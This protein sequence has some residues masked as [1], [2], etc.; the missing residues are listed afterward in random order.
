M[1]TGG[2]GL[3]LAEPSRELGEG[4]A[5]PNPLWDLEWMHRS[6]RTS[7]KRSRRN[8]R[9]R[10]FATKGTTCASRSDM[11][12]LPDEL[13]R[14]GVVAQLVAEDLGRLAC[15]NRLFRSYVQ[16]VEG[17]WR[18][19]FVK[20]WGIKCDERVRKTQ[21]KDW[22][23]SNP[24]L[25]RASELAG[26]WYKL[27]AMKHSVCS[28]E[29]PWLLPAKAEVEAMM[30]DMGSNA[31]TGKE[32]MAIFLLDGSGS[33]TGEDFSTMTG[34]LIPTIKKLDAMTGGT[35]KFAVLQF[36]NETRLEIP[37][38]LASSENLDENIRGIKRMNGGTN[39]ASPLR[40]VRTM[41][42]RDHTECNCVV[43]ILT[44]G[45]LDSYQTNDA[46]SE[47]KELSM[48]VDSLSIYAFGVGRG[49]EYAELSRLII[50]GT[51]S[52]KATK[53]LLLGRCFSLRT[54]NESLWG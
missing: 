35:G 19:Q 22:E 33:V 20:N 11:S 12:L 31:M 30:E 51:K 40:Q 10:R 1:A 18:S 45:R 6:A 54:T 43:A 27:F 14:Q 49:A 4:N 9:A 28:S 8:R 46:I 3:A 48:H 7:A 29:R 5:N 44:D 32:Y 25:E 2:G 42:G 47:A 50:N 24:L 23:E 53:S 41:L 15:V 39:I 34:F 38:C 16:S 52:S 13:V 21:E 36:S 37:L 17:V 26:G